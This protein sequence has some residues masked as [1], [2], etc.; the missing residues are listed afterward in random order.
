MWR[1]TNIAGVF[2]SPLLIYLVAAL[3]V[4]LP[5]RWLLVRLRLDRWAWNPTLADAALYICVLG[6]LVG[7]L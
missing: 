1:E 4:Y 2:I 6:V 5:L 7:L 3:L